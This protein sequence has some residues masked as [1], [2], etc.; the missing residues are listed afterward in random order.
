MVTATAAISK[1]VLGTPA[2]ARDLSKL[3]LL[4]RDYSWC[5]E[6]MMRNFGSDALGRAERRAWEMLQNH[7]RDGYDTWTRVAA[8]IRQIR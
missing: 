7:N 2:N 5:A 6:T 8:V 1:S 4:D 3:T